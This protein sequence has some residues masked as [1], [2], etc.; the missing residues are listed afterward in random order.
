[1]LGSNLISTEQQI[2]SKI[3]SQFQI[4][5]TRISR[6]CSESSELLD[7]LRMIYSRIYNAYSN[8]DF[9]FLSELALD[10]RFIDS[11][12]LL[13][14]VR[15]CRETEAFHE[16]I[17]E[18]LLLTS[19]H[20]QIENLFK[21]GVLHLIETRLLPFQNRII[22]V[23][24][25]RSFSCFAEFAYILFENETWPQFETILDFLSELSF[26]EILFQFDDHFEQNS[27][28]SLFNELLFANLKLVSQIGTRNSSL[29]R[30]FRPF[31]GFP[32]FGLFTR[33]VW[34]RASR[35]ICKF[36]GY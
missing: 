8:D 34:I 9:C 33:F 13:L 7:S 25:S 29:L 17:L 31:F 35:G 30:I 12:N 10:S 5:G 2:R 16:V 18:I 27:S 20:A 4:F 19:A 6:S 1:M 14:L 24:L 26:F 22:R 3:L 32:L 21:F 23:P 36:D 28:I 15:I 11:L